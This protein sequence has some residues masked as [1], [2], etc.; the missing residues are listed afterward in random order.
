ME[1]KVIAVIGAGPAGM[2]AA[3]ELAKSG[4]MVHVY[5]ASHQIGGLSKTITLWNQK[6]DLGPHRFFSND[7]RVNKLWLEVVQNDYKMVD[8][9]TRIYYKK[10]FFDYPLKPFNA[11]I[12]LGPIKAMACATSYFKQKIIPTKDEKTFET[13]VTR[14]FGHK[15]FSIFFKTYSE[16]LWGIS[17]KELDEDFAA[18]RIKK[19]SLFEAVK[20]AFVRNKKK[21]KT[22]VDQFAYPIEGTG[23]VYDRMSEFVLKNNGEVNLNLSVKKLLIENN[24][25]NGIVLSNNQEKKY[26]H[27]IST[28]PITL[29]INALGCKDADVI[30]ANNT[31]TFRN[32]ILVYLLIDQDN[33]FEDNWLYIHADDLK[34]GR[35]TN[36]KNWVPQI[37]QGEKKTI[38]VLEYWANDDEDLWLTQDDDLIDLGKS[39]LL[40]TGLIAN[41]SILEG[42]V[43]RL[44]KCYPVY[45]TGYKE[46]LKKVVNYLTEINNLSVIGRYGAFKYNNQDHSILMGILAAENISLDTK[47]NLW[48]INTDYEV[49]QEKSTITATGLIEE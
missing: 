46:P 19:L 16:K 3:Y 49:Y 34:V 9:L 43:I 35:I 22:L 45:K 10:K 24:E 42:K 36:F 14:R 41:A 37:N 44:P 25:V 12:Q 33:L 13:W 39:E 1:K 2:T 48:D 40:N 29:L 7:T 47:H 23:M 11:F 21:H 6:V 4:H 27:V 15:L 20:S 30:K 5:E 17:C 38:V 18:Q 28:M 8:R 32:T 26:D 31:L